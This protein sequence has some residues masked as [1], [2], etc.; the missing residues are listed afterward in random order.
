MMEF[1]AVGRL[2]AT[3]MLNRRE[4]LQAGAAGIVLAQTGRLSAQSASEALRSA[5]IAALDP[6]GPPE[7]YTRVRPL[8]FEPDAGRAA[9]ERFWREYESGKDLRMAERAFVYAF[10]WFRAERSQGRRLQ[11]LKVSQKMTAVVSQDHA[12]HPAGP[13]WGSVFLG[14]E[15]VT[16]G[17]LNTLKLMPIYMNLLE[18]AQQIDPDYYYGIS[19]LLRAKLYTKAP[20]F[21]VSVGNPAKAWP[22]LQRMEPLAKGIWSTWYLACAEAELAR[23]GKAAAY[24]W[25]DRM[26]SE[27]KPRLAHLA[28]DLEIAKR[29]ATS[30]REV[31]ESGTYDK[32]T[33]DPVTVIPEG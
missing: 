18:K 17:I 25:L 22:E 26:T 27:I 10:A 31:V 24:R 14:M 32:Y 2:E 4:L 29:D 21:P 3:R 30:F 13:V 8:F 1:V 12:R 11:I 5:P 9:V 28:Y 23:G 19:G 7:N 33:W 6:F 15:A 20:P 16:S